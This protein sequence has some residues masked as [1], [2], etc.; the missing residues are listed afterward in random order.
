MKHLF[1]IV[2][3]FFACTSVSAQFVARMEVKEPIEGI[4]NQNEVYALLPMKGQVEA[5]CP[6]SKEEVRNRLNEEVVFLKENPGYSDKGM[7]NLI[8]NCKG[9]VVKV[10]MDNKTKNSELD[11]QIVAVFKSL[12]TWKPGKLNGKKVDSSILWSFHVKEG[13]IQFE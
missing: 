2:L 7:V 6:L 3:A 8:I 12:G 5:V 13:Q 11:E 1:V 4:C 10:E 9:E